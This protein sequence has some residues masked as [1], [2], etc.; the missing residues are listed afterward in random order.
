MGRERLPERPAAIT[1]I[2]ITI[3]DSFNAKRCKQLNGIKPHSIFRAIFLASTQAF[4]NAEKDA[5]SMPND[6]TTGKPLVYS[7]AA[8]VSFSFTS[9]WTS[10]FLLLYL[11]MRD[12]QRKDRR[13]PTRQINAPKGCMTKSR[14]KIQKKLKYPPTKVSIILIPIFSRV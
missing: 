2:I 9:F 6:F 10:V 13:T 8:L 11:E 1:E 14:N 4:R 12:R 5:P 7:T 3:P